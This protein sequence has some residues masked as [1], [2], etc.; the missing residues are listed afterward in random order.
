[1]EASPP[2]RS[3][4]ALPLE[5]DFIETVLLF[6]NDMYSVAVVAVCISEKYDIYS[7]TE[8]ISGKRAAESINFKLITESP[9]L[10][11]RRNR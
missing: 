10:P 6:F 4:V 7:Q 1:M 11:C 3:P 2:P 5:D 9:F 8:T